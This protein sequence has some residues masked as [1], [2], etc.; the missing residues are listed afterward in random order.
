MSTN[1]EMCVGEL[2]WFGYCNG[3]KLQLLGLGVAGAKLAT[4]SGVRY[5]WGFGSSIAIWHLE[6]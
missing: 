4:A 2:R 3:N 5:P 1:G 6:L